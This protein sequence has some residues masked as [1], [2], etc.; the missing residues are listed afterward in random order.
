MQYVCGSNS[1]VC[2]YS[3]GILHGS[4]QMYLFLNGGGTGEGAG[5]LAYPAVLRFLFGDLLEG[6]GVESM[7]IN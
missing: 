2:R 5:F 3:G 1:I 4:C 6:K 7:V